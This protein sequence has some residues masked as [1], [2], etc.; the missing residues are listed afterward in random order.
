[1]PPGLWRAC[2][3][4][5]GELGEAVGVVA[6]AEPLAA[7]EDAHAQARLGQPAGGDPFPKPEPTTMAS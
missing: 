7:L 4:A 1:M 5:C 2:H 3:S 6:G